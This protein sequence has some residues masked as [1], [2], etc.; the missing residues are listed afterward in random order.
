[1]SGL[2]ARTADTTP[3]AG[4]WR[5]S[6]DPHGMRA[7]ADA[8]AIRRFL[9]ELG[10]IARDPATAYLVGGATA[11][12]VGWRPTTIDVDLRL[13]PEADELIRPIPELKVR[14]GINVELASPLDFLPEPSGWRDASPFVS[15][16][17][18]L[19]IRHMDP[20]L[21][22]LAKLERGF[23]QDLADVDAMLERGLVEPSRLRALFDDIRPRLF[24][25]PA[26]DPEHLRASVE[27]IAPD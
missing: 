27:A 3:S 4:D 7:P 14:L 20:A 26:V 23:G 18:P 21:Q 8:G 6:F 24:R 16:E 2:P 11:V 12:L 13:E 9:A 22:A 10:R 17:G 25:F 19:V 1:M 15:Q 5:A